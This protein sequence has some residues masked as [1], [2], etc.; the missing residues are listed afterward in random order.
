MKKYDTKA[1]F[2]FKKACSTTALREAACY[3]TPPVYI[4]IDL[5]LSAKPTHCHG[6]T[7]VINLFYL[8]VTLYLL[9]FYIKLHRLFNGTS[10]YDASGG[11]VAQAC[12]W[13]RDRL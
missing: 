3:V 6:R 7:P 12:H 10:C 5:S 11:V 9:W 8:S 1:I 2:L 4:G 13:K